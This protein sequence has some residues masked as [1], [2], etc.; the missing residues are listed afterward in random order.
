MSN[1]GPLTGQSLLR[2]PAG[3]GPV[4]LTSLL[5]SSG[6]GAVYRTSQAGHVAKIYNN[7]QPEHFRKLTA[8]IAR[9][10]RDPAAPAVSIAWPACILSRR[11]GEPVGFLMPEIAKA[12]RPTILYVPKTRLVDASGV[13]WFYLHSAALNVARLFRAI[14]ELG[15]VIGD[16]KPEN[17][18]VNASMQICAIDTDS[19][20][21]TDPATKSVYRC[22]VGTPDYTP[23]EL[24]GKDFTTIDRSISHDL[25]G[26]AALIYLF[27]FGKH[28][29]SGGLLPESMIGMETGERIKR[30]LWQWNRSTP[31][32]PHRGSLRIDIVHP[33]LV[34]L[35][36]RCFDRGGQRPDMRPTAKEWQTALELAIDDLMW[37]Q[38][39]VLHVHASHHSCPWCESARNGVDLFPNKQGLTS[40][41]FASVV[42]RL[43]R[44][45]A[46]GDYEAASALIK[47][48]GQLKSDPRA[49]RA[50]TEVQKQSRVVAQLSKF[51][52]AIARPPAYDDEN[53]T[54]LR[55]TPPAII[56]LAEKNEAAAP[57]LKRL[58]ALATAISDVEAAIAAAVPRNGLY[59][60]AGEDKILATARLHTQV[61]QTAPSTFPRFS[62]RMQDA[63]ERSAAITDLADAE[64]AGG[65]WRRVVAVLAKHW[66]RLQE[67]T[68]FQARRGHY[69][70][71]RRVAERLSE[72]VAAANRQGAD[73]EMVCATWE[74]A[75]EIA[76]SSL[77]RE[78][79]S[80]LAGRTPVE[81]YEQFAVRRTAL[82]AL[83]EKLAQMAPAGQPITE[84]TLTA[85]YGEVA[86]YVKANGAVPV[87]SPLQPRIASLEAAATLGARLR[88]LASKGETALIELARVWRAHEGVELLLESGLKETVERARTLLRA[89]DAFAAIAA[90]PKG[91]E[92]DLCRLWVEENLDQPA[93]SRSQLGGETFGARVDLARRRIAA[94][95]EMVRV[96]DVADA[97]GERTRQGEAAVVDAWE[98]RRE[99][100]S[101]WPSAGERFGARVELARKR[102]AGLDQLLAAVA[103]GKVED[104]GRAWGHHGLLSDL[105]EA[106]PHAPLAIEAAEVLALAETVAALPKAGSGSEQSISAKLARSVA[107]MD[108]RVVGAPL[109]SLGGKSISELEALFTSRSTFRHL[110][111]SCD[112][113]K[114]HDLFA[115]ADKWDPEFGKADPTLAA[116]PKLRE[117]LL[118]RERWNGLLT[119]ARAGNA[120]KV[121]GLWVDPRLE[122]APDFAAN[123]DLLRAALQKYL[124]AAERFLPLALGGVTTLPDGSSFLKWN[125]ND[126]SVTHAAVYVGDRAMEEPQLSTAVSN[127]VVTH[128][129]FATENGF[130]LQSPG[131]MVTAIVFP[132]FMVSGTIV[133]AK[134]PIIV[135][136]NGRRILRYSVRAKR[137][138][139]EIELIADR[140]F[141]LPP[142][143]LVTDTEGNSGDVVAEIG[144]KPVG[145]DARIVISLPS[146]TGFLARRK[147]VRLECGS[148]EDNA[149]LEIVHPEPDQRKMVVGR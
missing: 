57:L 80:D 24:W 109:S 31:L 128:E 105:A 21:V 37:C 61:L 94:S 39:S 101:H 60:R 53:L 114:G 22:P 99:L 77:T 88:T 97:T 123:T 95:N 75:P 124:D 126:A 9:P 146:R 1:S 115:L 100:F 11:A 32:T 7:P 85:A 133:Q 18:L 144:S 69:E 58:Q 103:A 64:A 81:A 23:P 107:Q 71:I 33:E 82:R 140:S 142:L 38:A 131:R 111:N 138:E 27:L 49:A 51:R 96:L 2:T 147:P 55:S 30:G 113:A 70:E 148:H 98:Q 17:L 104:I 3:G 125:W 112:T 84:A 34:A 36:R 48:H 35:F 19:F 145:A 120:T 28:P 4:K 42:H 102:L 15:Y 76:L 41:S 73:P 79:S 13:D 56:A 132:A 134:R 54:L 47:R 119:A 74:A 78:P 137:S 117:A 90:D 141:V 130:R 127:H 143:R 14:H 6:E 121:V 87:L 72:F 108:P 5:A 46:N 52:T 67:T 118:L 40:S 136:E 59:D 66:T 26:L 62:D 116:S 89:T 110:L 135:Q 93:V 63:W 83:S 20:Q 65:G 43:D 91:N 68:E 8:M 86:G 45:V 149:W 139:Q 16:V 44:M 92:E 50:R 129:N 29:F 122:S 12:K 106:R 10:P 25:F